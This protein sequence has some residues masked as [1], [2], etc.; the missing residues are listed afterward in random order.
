VN[1]SITSY[2]ERLAPSIINGKP[3]PGVIGMFAEFIESVKAKYDVIVID[4]PPNIEALNV[5][6]LYASNR[7]LLP[8]EIEAKSLRTM[9][10]NESFFMKLKSVTEA[11]RIDEVG[12]LWEKIL[13]IPNK[14]K[15]ENLKMKALSKL[16]DIYSSDADT[17]IELS[18]VVLPLSSIVDKCANGR[19]PLFTAAVKHG[20]DNKSSAI[21]AREFVDYLVEITHEILDMESDY[22]IFNTKANSMMNN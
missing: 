17:G 5:Q 1:Y 20:K 19:E 16:N 3:V 4:A 12:C 9:R 7:V 6:A 15:R 13:V 10:R 8:L 11:A 14:F 22:S 2:K 18:K 21:Q